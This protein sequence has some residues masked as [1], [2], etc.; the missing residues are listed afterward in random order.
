[1]KKKNI[2]KM[3]IKGLFI[4]I[5]FI[6][7]TKSFGKKY[8]PKLDLI[9]KEN[10]LYI[11]DKEISNF[12][13]SI[14]D[15]YIKPLYRFSYNDKNE[16]NGSSLDVNLVNDV[17]SKYTY[18]IKN[19]VDEKVYS[20]Y[21]NNYFKSLK[22]KN[23]NYVIFPF[24]MFTNNP[25]LYNYGPKVLLSYDFLSTTTLYIDVDVK[26]YGINNLLVKTYIVINVKQSIL[27]PAF[28]NIINYKKK[29][30]LSTDIVYGRVSDYL[31][32]NN[33]SLSSKVKDT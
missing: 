20:Y 30:L 17:L 8:L 10:N 18:D 16:I 5:F 22:T 15:S 21:M 31:G 19:K 32:Y 13:I 11:I 27:K 2:Y 23:N 6:I 9:I 29:F 24:G 3:L 7:F 4:F 25:F 26:N 33:L 12:V 1:M 14:K 28:K